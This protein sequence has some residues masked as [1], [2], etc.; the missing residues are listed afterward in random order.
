VSTA[1]T[2]T[3]SRVDPRIR[4]RRVAVRRAEA[5][6]R[7]RVL[8]VLL[9]VA[10]LGVGGWA[11][12]RSP[13]LDVDHIGIRGAEHTTV[14]DALA[15]TGIDRGD[16]LLFVDTG[17]V[18]RRLEALPWVADASVSRHFPGELRVDVREREARSW[19]RVDD[20]HVALVDATGRV[21]D[22]RAPNALYVPEL[23][24]A[25]AVPEAG[26]T[27]AQPAA[28][29]VAAA[30]PDELLVFVRG[31]RVDD[32]GGEGTNAVLVLEGGTEVRLGEPTGDLSDRFAVAIALL[33]HLDGRHVAY[34]DVSVPEAPVVG[35]GGASPALPDASAGAGVD[36]PVPGEERLE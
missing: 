24:D 34:L 3:V 28:A 18:A 13:L 21:L 4:A 7:L 35:P 26:E 25:G 29:A 9:V 31:V 16:P 2:G 12:V 30:I 17:A 11:A 36:S 15:A 8:A 14:E 20:E 10:A 22:D 23:L 19:V 27:I 6:R 32:A 5:R 1:P 33:G